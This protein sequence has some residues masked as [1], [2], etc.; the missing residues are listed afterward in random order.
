M[1]HAEALVRLRQGNPDLEVQ[2][3][4]LLL[5]RGTVPVE[6]GKIFSR[7]LCVRQTVPTRF[8]YKQILSFAR[9]IHCPMLLAF[10]DNGLRIEPPE[11]L[12]RQL[13]VLREA[14]PSLQTHQVVGNH[15]A[16]MNDPQPVSRLISTFWNEL[17]VLNS[18]L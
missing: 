18:K 3:A 2:S 1:S 12:Q 14:C 15:H 4:E 13:Q 16:H 8:S 5:E 10:A 9:R 7:D 6:G 11:A 17:G